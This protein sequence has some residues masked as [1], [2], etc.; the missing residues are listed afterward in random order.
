MVQYNHQQ[1]EKWQ[2]NQRWATGLLEKQFFY[3]LAEQEV[4]HACLFDGMYH[5]GDIKN[6]S[7]GFIR[8]IELTLKEFWKQVEKSDIK[9]NNTQVSNYTDAMEIE[10]QSIAAY[11]KFLEKSTDEKEKEFL[12]WIIEEE[13][14]HL[15]ALRNVHYYLTETADWLQ[16][17]ES[18]VWN[19]MNQ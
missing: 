2:R 5:T 10:K 4:Q 7:G 14:K 11:R 18:K 15:E 17:E 12:K 3:S 16:S 13:K 1:E 8:D 9:K 6:T 19:W